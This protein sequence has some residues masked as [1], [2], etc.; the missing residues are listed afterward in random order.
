[1][2]RRLPQVTPAAVERVLLRA[3][4]SLRRVKGSHHQYKRQDRP[5]LLVVVPFHRRTVPRGLL[6]RIIRD[7]GLTVEQFHD[8]L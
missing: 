4:F 1:M 3:G 2:S 6:R 5:E 8:L 7:A